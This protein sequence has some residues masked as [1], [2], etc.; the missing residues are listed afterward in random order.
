MGLTRSGALVRPTDTPEVIVLTIPASR[1]RQRSRKL[2]FPA[3]LVLTLA[4][5]SSGCG[6]SMGG[7]A[8]EAPNSLDQSGAESGGD[9]MPSSAGGYDSV[10]EAEQA[11]ADAEQQLAG[12][13]SGS[14]EA[15]AEGS[16]ESPP[17]EP[18]VDEGDAE[19]VGEDDDG[20]GR[21]ATACKALESLRRAGDAICRLAGEEDER[22]SR[23]RKIIQ[24]NTERV[25]E[26]G[27][28]AP[29]TDD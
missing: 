6:G 9:G 4:A 12:L 28:S 18:S 3:A 20:A 25:S 24:E 21:C 22:C 13:F 14:R 5:A 1:A 11:L 2:A 17:P 7:A 16:A 19:E 29:E 15:L 8:P 26:C 27:C 23:A 10:D